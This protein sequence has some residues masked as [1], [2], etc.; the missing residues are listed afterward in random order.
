ME[1]SIYRFEKIKL[2]ESMYECLLDL[3]KSND[4]N[5]SKKRIKFV[6]PKMISRRLSVSHILSVNSV[7]QRC[8]TIWDNSNV[9]DCD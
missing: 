5:C 8:I 4:N 2:I 7:L 6:D 3:M 9:H 1:N